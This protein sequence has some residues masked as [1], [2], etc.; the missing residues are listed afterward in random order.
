MTERAV[1]NSRREAAALGAVIVASTLTFWLLMMCVHE[2]GHVLAARA[3]GGHVAGVELSPFRLSRTDV[4]PN[5]MP[6]TVAWAGPLF[7]AIAPTLAV[8]LARL[9]RRRAAWLRAFAGF[10]LIANGLYLSTGVV[11][12]VGDADDLRRMGVS[13][14]MLGSV[15]LVLTA[16]G[17]LLWHQLGPLWGATAIAHDRRRGCA[18]A[19]VA[20]LALVAAAMFAFDLVV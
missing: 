2:L 17:G 13:V 20:A 10:C 9:A 18:R 15:G 1:Q 16:A 5:P 7:G 12:P 14:G 3:T 8:A 11:M 19:S 6:R 4:S